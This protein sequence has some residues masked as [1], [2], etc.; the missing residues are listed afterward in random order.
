MKKILATIIFTLTINAVL[1]GCTITG[2]TPATDE[3]VTVNVTESPFYADNTGETL[4]TNPLQQAIDYVNA[5][6]GG[7]VYFPAGIYRTT[8]LHLRSNVTLYISEHALIQASGVQA[9]WMG[10]RDPVIRSDNVGN[11]GIVGSGTI[12]GGQTAFLAPDDGVTWPRP[13]YIEGNRPHMIL[14]LVESYNI[15]VEGLTLR[16]SVT[17]TVHFDDCDWVVARHLTIRNP[18]HRVAEWTDGIDINGCRNVLIEYVD[19]ETGDDA[20]CI[21]NINMAHPRTPRRPSYN[22]IVR[23][24]VVASNCNALKIGTETYGDISNVLFYNIRVRNHTSTDPRN[25]PALGAMVVQSIDGAEVRDVTFRNI[26]VED[27]DT[28]LFIT[29]MDRTTNVPDSG[30]GSVR[31]VTF[32]NITVYRSTRASQ[33]T[34]EL[35]GYIH[36]VTLKNVNIRNYETRRNHWDQHRPANNRYPDPNRFG[37]MPAYGLFA[38]DTIGVIFKGENTFVDAGNSG[39]PTFDISPHYVSVNFCEDRQ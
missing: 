20:I 14:R 7:V 1:S 5:Q 25:R 8:T 17:W 23:N 29:V 2:R 18:V 4:V 11:I 22:I 19:I 27:V 6:G 13:T 32:E 28:P 24:S 35:G 39:R 30:F 21:K 34:T 33:F 38:I 9:D 10:N 3:R 15:L 36:N 37:R 16:N 26:I 31:N 12:D